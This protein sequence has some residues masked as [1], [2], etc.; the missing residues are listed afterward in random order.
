[1]KTYDFD[2]W[3]DRT[4]TTSIKHAFKEE[5]QVPSDAISLWVADMDFR[6][7]DEVCDAVKAAFF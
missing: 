4:E 1:M 7:P 6:S 2:T 3:I 5:F